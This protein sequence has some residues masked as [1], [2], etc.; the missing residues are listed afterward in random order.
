MRRAAGILLAFASTAALAQEAVTLPAVE[1]GGQGSRVR[2]Y[3]AGKLLG[4]AILQEYGVLAPE[5]LISVQ[6]S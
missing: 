3:H 5:R 1:P 4:T 6:Q 2:V